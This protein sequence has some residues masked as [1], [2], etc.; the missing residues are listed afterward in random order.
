MKGNGKAKGYY[1]ISY[2]T[3]SFNIVEIMDI[4]ADNTVEYRNAVNKG[5]TVF[6]KIRKAVVSKNGFTAVLNNGEEARV[7]LNKVYKY[8]DL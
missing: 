6:G 5:R 1:I 2:S 4:K 3:D 8:V 7:E